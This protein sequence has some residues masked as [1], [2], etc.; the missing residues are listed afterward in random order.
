M[1]SA[2]VVARAAAGVARLFYQLEIVGERPPAAGPLLLVAN[3][4]NSLLD[5]ALVTLATGRPARFL[6][7]STLFDD[8]TVGWLVRASGAIPVYRQ[9]DAGAQDA[10]AQDAGAAGEP[11]TA[12]AA[13]NAAMFRA[14]E[15]ALGA[16]DAIALFPEGT[17]HTRPSLAPL[18][19]GAARL[20][21]GAARH[22]GGAFPLVPIGITLD[23]RAVFRS[24]GLLVVGAPIAWDDLAARV[25]ASG[26][27]D[28]DDLD[29]DAVRALTARIDEA[30]RAVT[31]GYES[32]D[33]ARL[34][35]AAER[36]HTAAV[37]AARIGLPGAG[38]KTPLVAQIE[39]PPDGSGLASG[40]SAATA[41]RLGRYHLG[42]ALLRRARA[43]GGEDGRAALASLARALRDH[44]RLLGVLR[45]APADLAVPSDLGT[46]AGWAKRRLWLP[47]VA[48]LVAFGTV[49][50]WVPYRLT[51]VLAA[52]AT[53][54]DERDVLATSKAL[55]GG[56]CFLVWT[57]L[58]AAAAGVAV[59]WWAA[60]LVLL[61]APPLYVLTLFAGEGWR[62]AWRDARRFFTLRGRPDRVA[63]LRARQAALA[64]RV[65][66]V[67][68]Q[69]GAPARR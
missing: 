58:L 31:A 69:L 37:E 16:G 47:L 62:L 40:V 23:D 55:L 11:A 67:A 39:P 60:L 36:V 57:L 20:A 28:A 15:G 4:P 42:A 46:A 5:T 33:D 38:G 7:K 32:W 27:P 66:A 35:T 9:Q 29:H 45:L 59:A 3:H 41:G 61:L 24:T 52:R 49:L 19:T 54:P 53:A 30:L 43:E 12:R 64:R 56:A 63:G 65:E 1:S 68:A 25:R 22:L 26:A 10:G 14:A 51:G 44:E 34:V 21:L 8:R 17:S 13:G 18:K 2:S 6:A 50:A 48:A